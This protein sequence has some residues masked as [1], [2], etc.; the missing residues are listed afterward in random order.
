MFF[1]PSAKVRGYLHLLRHGRPR[2]S[3][4]CLDSFSFIAEPPIARS[5]LR[6]RRCFSVIVLVLI[7][8]WSEVIHR[9]GDE[10]IFRA[11]ERERPRIV[12]NFG[13]TIRGESSRKNKVPKGDKTMRRPHDF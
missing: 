11:F 1:S 10:S 6:G 5:R 12:N 7:V 13:P 2:Q 9:A 3:S 8:S 4:S